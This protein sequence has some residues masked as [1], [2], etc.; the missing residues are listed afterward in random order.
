V[1]SNPDMMCQ[2]L[3]RKAS[4]ILKERLFQLVA[5]PDSVHENENDQN[6]EESVDW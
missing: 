6:L 2:H 3:E 5:G 4:A 1:L